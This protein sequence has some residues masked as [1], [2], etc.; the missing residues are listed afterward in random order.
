M[1]ISVNALAVLARRVFPLSPRGLAI[2]LIACA[3]LAVGVARADLAGLFWGSSFLLYTLYALLAGH[4][5]RLSLRRRRISLPEDALRIDLQAAGLEPGEDSEA[6]VSSQ[7]PR[8]FP[9]GFSVHLS[10]PLSW[11]ERRIDGIRARLP[12][13]SQVTRVSFRAGYRGAYAG[14]AAVLEAHDVLGLTAHREHFPRQD[15]LVVFPGSRPGR[16]MANL[17]EQT[18]EAAADSRRRRRSEELLEARKYYPGDDVRR[19]NWK[20]FAHLDELFLRVGEEVPPPESRILFVLDTTSNPLV[21]RKAAADYL[22]LL[23]ESCASIMDGLV[24]RGLEVMLSSPGSRECR[25][26]GEGTHAALRAALAGAW[27][28]TAEWAPELPARPLQV[29]VFSTPGS[30]G[31]PA[32]IST[33]RARAWTA[34]LFLQG[35]GPQSA[36]RRPLREILFL[37]RGPRTDGISARVDSRER[38]NLTVALRRDIETYTGAAHR[39]RHA[40]E[41]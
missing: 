28:T 41:I 2:L 29:A 31:L 26:Y 24:S 33:I 4:L 27:W 3:V 30:P 8:A 40:Q 38:A 22:D 20:V 14:S 37:P 12:G 13:G 39:V 10:L 15:S 36:A 35:L 5:F 23:V 25:P 9:P 16:E 1:G 21:P 11:H 6:V 32:I 17:V 34:S 7:L 19:L 18:D